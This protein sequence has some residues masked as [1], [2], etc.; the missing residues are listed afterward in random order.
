[1]ESIKIEIIDVAQTGATVA[2]GAGQIEVVK[3]EAIEPK[4][5][6]RTKTRSA[7]NTIIIVLLLLLTIAIGILTVLIIQAEQHD[8]GGLN[9]DGFGRLN[10]DTFSE[11]VVPVIQGEGLRQPAG[12][13]P[14]RIARQIGIAIRAYMHDEDGDEI[15]ATILGNEISARH[16]N[17]TAQLYELAG[18]TDPETDAWNA[19]KV[20]SYERHFAIE[21]NIYPTNHEI[22]R[23]TQE[24]REMVEN[25]PE[26]LKLLETLLEAAGIT[27]DEYWND[28]KLRYESPT[29]LTSLIVAEYRAA[30][31]WHDLTAETIVRRAIELMARENESD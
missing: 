29:Q 31:G 2:A 30:N 21:R 25:T 26:A 7:H 20:Q 27:K 16:F 11:L 19:I 22:R 8:P 13:N 3:T 18:S 15:I 4:R 6:K 28:F 14:N 12:P 23:F 9:R 10:L 24:M 17:I 1:M 5:S